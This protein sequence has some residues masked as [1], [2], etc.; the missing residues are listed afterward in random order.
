MLNIADIFRF[1]YHLQR[2]LMFVS[3]EASLLSEGKTEDCE[4]FT[5]K[6]TFDQAEIKTIC[7]EAII[8]EVRN[9]FQPKRSTFK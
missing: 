1:F 9:L 6:F 3:D 5:E 7:H 4:F 2:M 8:K